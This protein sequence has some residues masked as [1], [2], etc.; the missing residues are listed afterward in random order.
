VDREETEGLGLLQPG[1]AVTPPPPEDFNDNLKA[2]TSGL[3]PELIAKMKGAFGDQLVIEG[4]MMRWKA[5][6]ATVEP[7]KPTQRDNPVSAALD[8]KVRGDLRA[9]VQVGIAAMD[10]VH[11]DGNLPK[12]PLRGSKKSSYGYFRRNVDLAGNSTADHI[13]VRASGEWPALTTVHEAGHFLDLEGIGAKGTFASATGE[14]KEVLDAA[15]Q[16]QAIAGLQSKMATTTSQDIREHIR[17][18]LLTDKEIWA[19]AY[20]QYIAERSHSA[21][22][23]TQLEARLAKTEF[24]QWTTEDFAPVAQAIDKLFTQLG[25]L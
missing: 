14:L 5:E 12:I 15:R 8:L 18:Y 19:R 16:T 25:W 23:K 6:S 17:D 10:E 2:S 7:P 20:S 4:D 21:P 22:L 13:G 1:E 11:D 9:Q 24:E 3:E